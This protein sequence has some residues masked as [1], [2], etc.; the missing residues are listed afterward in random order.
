MTI[1]PYVVID[2]NDDPRLQAMDFVV[3]QYVIVGDDVHRFNGE[4]LV[5]AKW[6]NLSSFRPKGVEQRALFDLLDDDART[7]KV[8]KG[9]AGS[10]KTLATIK[11]ALTKVTQGKYEKV[12]FIRN[13][14]AAGEQIGYLKGSLT[15][16]L[17]PWTAPIID[18]LDGGRYEFERLVQTG[19]IEFDVT[20]FVQG[21][22]IANAF[23][24][25]TEAQNLTYELT[26]MCGTR[27][28]EGSAIVF[29]GDEEQV[30]NQA[31]V[32]NNGFKRLVDA[33]AGRRDFGYMRLTRS[34]RSPVA[35]AFATLY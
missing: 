9:V 25:C 4:Y 11:F 31:L 17:A 33:F 8:V 3:N 13:P 18:N 29:E 20:S 1:E 35:E 23:I 28:G 15:E 21:R 32:R 27:V 6:T 7:I 14:V 26:K 22:S 30:V 24:V 19:K 12:V 5:P 10:G 34:V 16:K 2:P